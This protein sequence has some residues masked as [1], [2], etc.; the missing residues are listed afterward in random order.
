QGAGVGGT[1]PGGTFTISSTAISGVQTYLLL[2]QATDN[3]GLTFSGV[4]T[5]SFGST[6]LAASFSSGVYANEVITT[7]GGGTQNNSSFAFQWDLTGQGIA[8]GTALTASWTGI[9]NSSIYQIQANQGTN[10]A[11]VVPEP[12]AALLGCAAIGL[13]MIRRRRA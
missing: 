7:G 13:T 11:Q 4:P 12:S 8:E 1:P 3:A 9:A 5:L 6:T 10:F 2:I